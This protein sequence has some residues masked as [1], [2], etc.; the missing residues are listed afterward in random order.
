MVGPMVLQGRIQDLKKEGAQVARR[1]VF[2]H[3][4]ANL[5]DF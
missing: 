3:I 1:R 2:T 5:E 4:L